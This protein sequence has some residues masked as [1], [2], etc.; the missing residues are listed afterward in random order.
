MSSLHLQEYARDS[1]KNP[2]LDEEAVETLG[3]ELQQ[4][5]TDE[6]P[7]QADIVLGSLCAVQESL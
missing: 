6:H 3:Y 5:H 1:N 4:Y 2:Y 7:V